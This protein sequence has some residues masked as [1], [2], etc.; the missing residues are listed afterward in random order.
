MTTPQSTF[1]VKA[2]AQ[3]T[4]WG[5]MGADEDWAICEFNDGEFDA[6]LL[7]PDEQG[8]K[9]CA[10]GEWAGY[11][12]TAINL[13]DYLDAWLPAMKED[14]IRINI[15]FGPKSRGSLIEPD[16]LSAAILAARGKAS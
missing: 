15:N 1:A 4:V 12:P 11:K 13:Q 3:N 6:M 16:E 14:G 7:W 10:V 2:I 8:A 9:A 5:L